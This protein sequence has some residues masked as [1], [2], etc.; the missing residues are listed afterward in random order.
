[1][2]GKEP[3]KSEDNSYLADFGFLRIDPTLNPL[4]SQILSLE[5]I[6]KIVEKIARKYGKSSSRIVLRWLIQQPGVTSVIVGDKKCQ[7]VRGKFRGWRLAFGGRGLQ[8][9]RR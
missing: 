7:A 6:V 2:S 4:Q 9:I 1:M 5:K 3:I 8:E